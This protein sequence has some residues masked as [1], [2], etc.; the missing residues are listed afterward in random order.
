[1]VQRHLEG[2]TA[3]V[4]GSGRSIG[5]A[6]ARR[7]ASQGARVVVN[8]RSTP[9]EAEAV[10]EAASQ[11]SGTTCHAVIG[12]VSTERDASQVAAQA[13]EEVG[14][15]DILVN[16]V[17]VSPRISFWEMTLEDWH[18]AFSINVDS[19]L[20]LSRAFAPGMVEAG[21]G[22]IVN[23]SGHAHLSIEGVGVHTK[24]SKA[25]VV[26]LTRGLAGTLAAYGVTV[27]H[28]APSRIETPE[29]RNKY[30]R[31]RDEV[32]WSPEARGAD[33]VP[34]GRMGRPEDVANVVEFLVREEAG[35][36]TGQSYLVNGGTTV[37]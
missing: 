24:A 31:D 1:M 22:R 11:L 15:I 36:L 7:L 9:E 26:G 21:W 29:R 5:A 25:A 13:L 2:K 27:N 30:Y 19:A 12:D 20:L 17:G 34:V 23:L 14:R 10:A 37:L 6:I 16:G 35:Y 3:F 18:Q 32:D 4:S 28:V 33:T 8:S